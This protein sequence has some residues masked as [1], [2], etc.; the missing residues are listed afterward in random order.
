MQEVDTFE[1]YPGSSVVTDEQI[2]AFVRAGVDTEHHHAGMASMLPRE[3]GDVIESKLRVYGLNGLRVVDASI[4]P[5]LPAAHLQSTLYGIA[6]K[7]SSNHGQCA[8]RTWLTL[9]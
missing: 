3:L 4:I 5:M 9:I 8:M 7:V 1:T 2:E 6:E